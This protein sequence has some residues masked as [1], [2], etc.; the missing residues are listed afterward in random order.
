ME[1]QTQL[2]QTSKFHLSAQ[3]QAE[4]AATHI[5]GLERAQDHPRFATIRFLN[6]E[7]KQP[8]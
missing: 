2:T 1:L 6:Q 4:P 5:C 8:T 7:R 3:P